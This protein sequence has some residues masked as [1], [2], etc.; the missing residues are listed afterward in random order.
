LDGDYVASVLIDPLETLPTSPKKVTLGDAI[1]IV[2]WR[3]TRKLKEIQREIISKAY[4]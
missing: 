4:V 2:T 1:Q 3:N